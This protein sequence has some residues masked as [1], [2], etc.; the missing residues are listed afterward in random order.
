MWRVFKD[1][2]HQ[3]PDRQGIARRDMCLDRLALTLET[4]G[5]VEDRIERYEILAGADAALLAEMALDEV[6]LLR[7]ILIHVAPA[8]LLHDVIE[9]PQRNIVVRRIGG[10]DLALE[11]RL[12]EILRRVRYVGGGE[13]LGVVHVGHDAHHRCP[14]GA[15]GILESGIHLIETVGLERRQSAFF[16]P[17]YEIGGGLQDSGVD[18][19]LAGGELRIDLLVEHVRKAAADCD[20]HSRITLFENLRS[21]LPGRRRPAHIK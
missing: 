16:F 21:R 7:H 1:R 3:W 13:L 18:F 8:V 6:R 9:D 12:K 20:F 5:D 2:A 4:V 14:V 19:E 11:L 17:A 15:A 10:D